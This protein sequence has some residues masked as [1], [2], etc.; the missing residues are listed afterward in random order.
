MYGWRVSTDGSTQTANTMAPP[1]TSPRPAT[2]SGRRQLGGTRRNNLATTRTKRAPIRDRGP[3][4]D[5][6]APSGRDAREWSVSETRRATPDDD[7]PR[8][9]RGRT[10]AS[11]GAG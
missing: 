5:V 4:G 3:M 11:R 2:A 9:P 10:G 6:Y 8:P 1:T 7:G